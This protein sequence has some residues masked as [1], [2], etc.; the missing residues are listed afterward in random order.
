[1]GAFGDP[2]VHPEIFHCRIEKLLER[3][4]EPVDLVD[5]EHVAG[6]ERR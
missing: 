5:E 6:A 4:P 2:D 1:M 3:R